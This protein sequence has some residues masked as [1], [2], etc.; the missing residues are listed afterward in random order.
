VEARGG[1]HVKALLRALLGLGLL[2]IVIH[3][4]D[5][6]EVL[7]NLTDLAWGGLALAFGSQIMGKIV[8]T[9]R[10]REILRANGLF[11]S[12]WELI[13]LVHIGLFYNSFLPTSMGG[14]VVRGYYVSRG[15]DS[16]VASYAAL[17]VERSLGLLL[18][19][20]LAGVAATIALAGGAPLPTSLLA[21]IAAS[22]L[23]AGVVGTWIFAWKGWQTRIENVPWLKGKARNLAVGLSRAVELFHRP[24][25][26]RLRIVFDSL[27]L[28]VIGVMFHVGCARAVGLDTP[29]L[30]FF[31]IVPASVIASMLPFS[32]NG[33]GI[34]EGVLVG[35]LAAYG[36]PPATAGAFA[37]LALL[38]S[39]A[40]A[41]IGGLINPF[42]RVPG[43]EAS[44]V[45]AD[46]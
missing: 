42:Y 19:A 22:G 27:L 7:S 20:T 39:T 5:A 41:L 4:L 9:D 10:W 30:V 33:L 12:F 11:R 24:E 26:R 32:L 6:R 43:M 38:V 40:F 45:P 14:D 44:R 25:T 29:T 28:Q 37:V 18:M 2:A 23:G 15:R 17:F 3:Q 31:L 16:M 13:A 35:L 36:S 21:G 34:R 1:K 46:T 8:W